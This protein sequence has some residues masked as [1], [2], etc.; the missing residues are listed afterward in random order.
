MNFK[1]THFWAVV[2]MLACQ[3]DPEK[4]TYREAFLEDQQK[5]SGFFQL[6]FPKDQLKAL[7]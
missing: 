1:S 6:Q 2:L 3:P 4:P 5:V 7:D